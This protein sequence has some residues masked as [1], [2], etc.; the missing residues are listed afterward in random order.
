M[1]FGFYPMPLMEAADPYVG[2]LLE[3]V[4]VSDDP[5]EVGAPA[6]AEAHSD[7]DTAEE[8]EN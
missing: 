2:E 5:P 8:G 6:E 4:G 1:L 7:S 3:Q